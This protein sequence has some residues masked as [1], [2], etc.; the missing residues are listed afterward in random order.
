MKKLTLKD[1]FF[2]DVGADEKKGF[3]ENTKST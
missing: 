3:T 2:P 1:S